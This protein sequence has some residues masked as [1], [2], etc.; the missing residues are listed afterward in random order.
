VHCSLLGHSVTVS[1]IGRKQIIIDKAEE[2]AQVLQ[3]SDK[4]GRAFTSL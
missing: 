4:H 2:E 1:T 3:N